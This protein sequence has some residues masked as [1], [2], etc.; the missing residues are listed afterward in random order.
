MADPG[1][2]Q[3]KVSILIIEFRGDLKGSAPQYK[4]VTHWQQVEF[5]QTEMVH[6]FAFLPVLL[7]IHL[8]FFLC[9]FLS[10]GDINRDGCLLS[11]VI[12]LDHTSIAASKVCGSGQN[13]HTLLLASSW[14]AYILL[15][16]LWMCKKHL[17]M[18]EKLDN[19]P[20]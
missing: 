7:F 18:D 19:W 17:L 11:N 8:D 3:I 10:F 12:E 5:I 20:S 1:L 9:D 16:K 4:P 15:L 14:G 2:F 6:I 13:L